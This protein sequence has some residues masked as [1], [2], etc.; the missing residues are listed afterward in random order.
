[1]SLRYVGACPAQSRSCGL[2]FKGV[3]ADGE[4]QVP[5]AMEVGVAFGLHPDL[6]GDA[7]RRL[8]DRSNQGDHAA[9][10]HRTER[11]VADCAA[12]LGGETTA[13]ISSVNEPANLGLLASVDIL[14]GEAHLAH[15]PPTFPLDNEP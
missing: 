3:S 15:T 9:E 8:V 13:L 1:M 5:V 4:H 2:A 10:S 7:L 14:D 11:V 6:S 12:G